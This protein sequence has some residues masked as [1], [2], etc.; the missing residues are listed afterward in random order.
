M[1]SEPKCK[2]MVIGADGMIG[3][4]LVKH[5]QQEGLSVVGTSRRQKPTADSN[6]FFLDM[7]NEVDE[8]SLPSA[9]L[10]FLCAAVSNIV[11]CEKS[12]ELTSRINVSQT[13]NIGRH[14]MRRGAS[15]IFLSSNAVFKGDVPAP[16]EREEPNPT[17]VYGRQ[18]REAEQS[19]SKIAGE[20]GF[21]ELS[22]VRLTKVLPKDFPLFMEWRD[23]FRMGR[24]IKPLT[25]L[26]VSPISLDFA[27]ASLCLIGRK[28]GGGIFHLSG[29]ENLSYASL[30][31]NLASEWG[32][33]DEL[34]VPT[35]STDLG[36]KLFWKPEYSS[37]GMSE[38]FLRTS[39]KSQPLTDL[40]RAVSG[41]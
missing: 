16:N 12:P 6:S 29:Q 7:S 30:A 9:D 5:L 11:D 24:K 33:K 4:A 40:V 32:C 36:V 31:E 10:V 17:T 39:L 22:I 14:Y 37:L 26:M 15:V 2:A 23:S 27:V 8:K 25:D 35:S 41:I 28:G 19:L 34:I 18:K 13:V 20:E 1:S 3:R 38:T 21:D